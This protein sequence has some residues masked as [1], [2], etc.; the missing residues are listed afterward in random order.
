MKKYW[1]F[2]SSSS[3]IRVWLRPAVYRVVIVIDLLTE[4]RCNNI[5]L[6]RR[7]TT[8]IRWNTISKWIRIRKIY[9]EPKFFRL[10]Y[11]VGKACAKRCVGTL[12]TVKIKPSWPEMK[13]TP[14]FTPDSKWSQ[15]WLALVCKWGCVYLEDDVI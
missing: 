14:K 7:F 6:L 4:N 10:T 1:W 13:D 8:T 2:L 5:F 15:Q 3:R 9:L 12:T 11:L